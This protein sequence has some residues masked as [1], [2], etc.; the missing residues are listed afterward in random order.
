MEA[1]FGSAAIVGKDGETVSCSMFDGKIVGLYFSAHWCPPCRGFTPVL[2]EKYKELVANGKPFEVIFVSSDRDEE[3]FKEY[4]GSMPWMAL[5]FSDRE[6][7]E[8]LSTKFE[9]RGIPSLVLIDGT[10][11]ETITRDGRSAIMSC[12]FDK[13]KTYEADKAAAAAELEEKLKT[14]PEEL[15]HSSHDCVLKKMASVYRG[16]Y[17]CDICNGGGEGWVYHCDECGFD[18]H[19]RCVGAV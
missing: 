13:L 1:L 8:M 4:Y 5:A 10:T 9:V 12:E 11:G 3:A 2:G 17:G 18:A 7:K 15:T 6:S 19:P 16:Q 14:A